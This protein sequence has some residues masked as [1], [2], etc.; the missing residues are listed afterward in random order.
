MDLT[1]QR[2]QAT[3]HSTRGTLTGIPGFAFPTLEPPPV[4][5]PAFDNCPICFPAGRFRIL[6]QHSPHFSQ[7]LGR[8]VDV[9]V[10]QD[11]PGFTAV[12]LH[13]GNTIEAVTSTKEHPTF[14]SK[15]CVLVGDARMSADE[16]LGTRDA[17]INHVWP[18]IAAAI[19]AGEEVW[20]E[21][22]DPS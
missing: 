18:A 16:I 11:V 6:M 7:I 13:F 1:L 20:I 4:P 17:C 12:E 14:L 10:L 8:N 5:D 21:V 22:I 9:P 15:G 3:Q 2:A 19:A